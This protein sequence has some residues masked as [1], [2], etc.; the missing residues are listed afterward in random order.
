MC[1]WPP[2]S[3]SVDRD[4]G[5]SQRGMTPD[6]G[7]PY[8][9]SRVRRSSKVWPPPSNATPAGRSG[10]FPDENDQI[11]YAYNPSRE[12]S[13][14]PGLVYAHIP[15]TYRPPPNTQYTQVVNDF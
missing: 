5:S 8:Y 9:D 12:A 4:F 11:N 14:G 13:P 2:R 6:R 15:P 7:E 10:Y 3:Q 1:S